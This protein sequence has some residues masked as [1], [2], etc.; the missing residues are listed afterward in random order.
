MLLTTHDRDDIEAL[1]SRVLLIT[2][3]QSIF[4]GSL[5]ALKLE[6]GA[7]RLLIVEFA[8]APGQLQLPDTRLVRTQKDRVE[9]HCHPRSPDIK[10]LVGVLAYYLYGNARWRIFF[11]KWHMREL[12][13][14][15]SCG[16]P[17]VRCLRRERAIGSSSRSRMIAL[18]YASAEVETVGGHHLVPGGHKVAHEL[19]LRVVTGVDFRDGPQ[20]RI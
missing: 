6:S 17:A 7:E 2:S 20:L 12:E 13:G 9:I 18:V 1:C 10:H 15:P 14:R 5:P 8:G 16:P 19:I 4:D 11:D 3:G